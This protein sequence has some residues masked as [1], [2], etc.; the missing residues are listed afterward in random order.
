LKK[1]PLKRRFVSEDEAVVTKT[2]HKKPCADCPFA[3]TAIPGWLGANTIQ[4][5]VD[6][7]HG[8]AF[9]HCHCTKNQQCAGAAIFRANLL[10]VPRHPI[11]LRLPED[12]KLCFGTTEEFVTHH[13]NTM[14]A[15]K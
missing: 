13:Q 15:F 9:I 4:E 1:H 11:Q 7:I 6:M 12:T 5:W 10:K 8:E 2:Q 3:R 14:G